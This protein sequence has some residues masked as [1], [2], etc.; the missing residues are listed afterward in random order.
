MTFVEKCDIVVGILWKRFGT[1][2]P[3]MS[4]ETGWRGESL[5]FSPFPFP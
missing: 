4:G 2:I 3:E 5:D 1:P